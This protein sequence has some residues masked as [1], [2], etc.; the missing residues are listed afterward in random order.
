MKLVQVIKSSWPLVIA[1]LAWI[2]AHA[3]FWDTIPI[4]DAA[5]VTNCLLNSVIPSFHL[6][7]LNCHHPSMGYLALLAIGQIIDPGNHVFL[8]STNMVLGILGIASFYFIIVFLFF[9]T[10]NGIKS[11]NQYTSS[12]EKGLLTL[13]LVWNPLFFASSLAPTLDFAVTVFFLASI[14]SLMHKRMFATIG[15][16]TFLVF[17]KEPGILL[18]FSIIISLFFY[19]CIYGI[20]KGKNPWTHAKKELLHI[21][22]YLFPLVLLVVYFLYR[23]FV[24]NQPPFWPISFSSIFQF[25]SINQLWMT[26]SLVRILQAFIFDFHWLY[27]IPILFYLLTQCAHMVHRPLLN[28]KKI[29]GST[30]QYWVM[31]IFC[32]STFSYFILGYNTYTLPRYV[33]PLIPFLI[34]F[35]YFAFRNLV[36]NT[37]LRIPLLVCA[38]SLFILQ[39]FQTVDP[40]SKA[41][42]GTFQFG[43]HAMLRMTSLVNECCG[44]AGK[45]HLAYNTE[46]SVIGDLLDSFYQEIRISP[47]MPLLIGNLDAAELFIQADITTKKRTLRTRNIIIPTIYTPSDLPSMAKDRIPNQAYFVYLPWSDDLSEELRR[48]EKFYS[49]TGIKTVQKRGY[50]IKLYA[51]SK[52]VNSL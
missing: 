7:R 35:A 13:F 46:F 40:V 12:I 6:M 25:G 32:F 43:D 2:I 28:V 17:S 48:I 3:F 27:T 41:I 38:L 51:L 22:P 18:Y 37:R 9:T 10:G 24:E 34:L 19:R 5:S 16:S 50:A 14:A 47:S 39:T 20:C 23:K 44:V 15:W 11:K 29:V 31:L 4:W 42:F 30:N 26:R 49:I 36:K 52:K 21:A 1:L 45:D 8:T 33:I